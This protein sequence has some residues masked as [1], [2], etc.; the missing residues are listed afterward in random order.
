MELLSGDS[1]R[2][3]EVPIDLAHANDEPSPWVAMV[4]E[5]INSDGLFTTSDR[6]PIKLTPNQYKILLTSQTCALAML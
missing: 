1:A 6:G 4:E 5:R 3:D 2:M